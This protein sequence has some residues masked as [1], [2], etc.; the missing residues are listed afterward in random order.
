MGIN[1]RYMSEEILNHFSNIKTSV[2]GL[3][4]EKDNP[5]YYAELWL[6]ITDMYVPGI[7]Y[8][9]YW[10]S[11]HGRVYTSLRSPNYPNGGI[12]SPSCN[13]HGYLQINLKSSNGKIICCKISRL[14]M[15]HFAYVEGCIYYEVDHLDGNKK[16]NKIWNLEWVTPQENVHRAINNNL[17]PLSCSV[18][19]GILLSDN[20]ARL[21]YEEALRSNDYDI[22]SKRYKVSVKY[23][24][25]LLSGS[26]RPY[27]KRSHQIE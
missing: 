13:Q 10:I 16:N 14:V 7:L 27:I 1:K 17:R 21:L 5:E 19:D 20:D 15:L 23:I 11:N 22:L 12:M 25:G 18:N 4:F 8:G 26:I 3:V 24:R 9:A 2:N 6:P